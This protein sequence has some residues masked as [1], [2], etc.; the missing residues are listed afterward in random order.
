MQFGE[1]EQLSWEPGLIR[2]GVDT[3]SSFFSC[4]LTALRPGYSTSSQEERRKIKLKFR[5]E[6]AEGLTPS[7]FKTLSIYKNFKQDHSSYASYVNEAVKLL[8]ENATFDQ[9]YWKAFQLLLSDIN[10]DCGFHIFDLISQVYQIDLYLI[11]PCGQVLVKEKN[12][13]NKLSIILLY[14]SGYELVARLPDDDSGDRTTCFK[15]SSGDSLLK[16]FA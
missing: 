3:C 9:L 7:T 5:T 4:I 8:P 16:K 2:I 12:K 15:N 14:L 1:V 11:S 6:L 10:Y 13:I